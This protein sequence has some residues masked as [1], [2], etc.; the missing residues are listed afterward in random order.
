MF[1]PGATH[2]HD[3]TIIPLDLEEFGPQIKLLQIRITRI[4]Q[5]ETQKGRGQCTVNYTGTQS[6]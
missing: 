3:D 2:Q 1:S 6:F 4:V 5:R